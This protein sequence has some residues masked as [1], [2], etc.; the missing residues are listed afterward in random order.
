MRRKTYKKV[1]GRPLRPC[2]LKGRRR[3]RARSA[4]PFPLSTTVTLSKNFHDPKDSSFAAL[5]F[6]LCSSVL[7]F[8][9]CS[10]QTSRLSR[11][12][13]TKQSNQLAKVQCRQAKALSLTRERS[14]NCDDRLP[15]WSDLLG[16]A[17]NSFDQRS[18]ACKLG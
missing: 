18:E 17:P 3:A 9:P 6:E 2:E 13:S 7:V 10:T 14:R 1:I 12:S 16:F 4:A 11:G 8:I 15:N 5:E